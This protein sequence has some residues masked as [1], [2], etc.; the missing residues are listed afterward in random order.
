LR[1]AYTGSKQL[2]EV[3]EF[4]TKH[5]ANL[6]GDS[7]SA[8]DHSGFTKALGQLTGE[9]G[10]LHDYITGVLSKSNFQHVGRLSNFSE[11]VR[12]GLDANSLGEFSGN[13]TSSAQAT[14]M[15]ALFEQIEQDSISAKK[16]S[17]RLAASTG[18]DISKVNKNMIDDDIYSHMSAINNL[19]DTMNAWSGKYGNTTEL[20]NAVSEGGFIDFNESNRTTKEA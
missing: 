6:Q 7:K 11:F 13:V 20:L 1:A 19:M 3:N 16:V 15:R 17:E 5:L 4:V 9:S 8:N 2:S 12:S 18:G 14:L 10:N